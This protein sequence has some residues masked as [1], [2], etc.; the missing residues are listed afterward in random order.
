MASRYL[1]TSIDYRSGLR[2]L[3]VSVFCYVVV[4]L[5]SYALPLP[6]ILLF[7]IEALLFIGLYLTISPIV[8]SLN[9]SDIGC[10]RNAI[11]GF[12]IA[13]TVS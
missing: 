13:I 5:V 3:F 10:L 9:S 6:P 2:I 4:V 1:S 11:N 7:S 8:G 12:K